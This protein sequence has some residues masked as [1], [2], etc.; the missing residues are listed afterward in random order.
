VAGNVACREL[1][2]AAIS[3][4]R[5]ASRFDD[6]D[7]RMLLRRSVMPGP[8]R[9]AFTREPDYF[10]AEGLA[11]AEDFA[12]VARPAGHFAGMGRCSINSLY[13]NGQVQR[14]GYLGE[15]RTLP[16]T[17]A[18]PRLL[19][20]AY[21]FMAHTLA[22][23][24]VDAFF[25]SIAVDN[26]RARRVLE[27]GPALGL[28]T[29]RALASL[30]T[31]VA[32]IGRSASRKA[33]RVIIERGSDDTAGLTAFLQEQAS[34]THLSLAWNCRQWSALAR[35]GITP[36]DF[37]VVREA[38]RIV[39]AAAVW[40]QRAFRQTLVEGYGGALRLTWP[41]VNLVQSVRGLPHLPT[42]GTALA[43]GVVLGASVASESAWPH[44]WSALRRQAATTGLSWLT[45]A[46]DAR[47]PLLPLLRSLARAREYHTMLY[48][49]TG[50][51]WPAAAGAWDARLFRP[52]VG[53][54]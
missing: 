16:G 32:P 13:R 30:V 26:S 51:D 39:A 44:L 2:E 53:L 47:D 6:G 24:S 9:V 11:G 35:S 12:V 22:N 40:D 28:P 36:S 34:R 50:K 37:H 42:R 21:A 29:Y 4:F 20:D 5:L 27:R 17:P 14:V 25:T 1:G 33:D 48:E 19:R 7:M 23:A 31:L 52:E 10:A 8:V 49:V 54:L 46:L 45:L 38:D 41:L 43:Q 15:L 18:L 3:E